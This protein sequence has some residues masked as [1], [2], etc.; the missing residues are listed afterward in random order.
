MRIKSKIDWW[1]KFLFNCI[2]ICLVLAFYLIPTDERIIYLIIGLPLLAFIL[3]IYWGTFYELRDEYLYCRSGPFVEKIPYVNIKSVRLCKN[4][5]SSMALAKE[6]IEI[7]QHNKSFITGTTYI[8][9]INRDEFYQMLLQR[10][11]NLEK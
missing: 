10:C 1:V 11:T 2:A 3:S 7:K 8:S 6:R 4:M 9:P 5:F